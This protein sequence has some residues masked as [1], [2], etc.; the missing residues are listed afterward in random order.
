[1]EQTLQHHGILGQKW[2]VRRYQNPDGS[3]TPAG[4]R[5]LEKLDQKWARKQGTKIKKQVERSVRSDMRPVDRYLNKK[6]A[7]KG[8]RYM[9]ERNQHLANLMNSKIG[10][11]PA[12]SGRVLRFVAKRGDLGVHVALADANYNMKNLK[13]GVYANGKVAYKK[14]NVEVR[15][16]ENSGYYL[17]HVEGGLSLQHHGIKG[18]RWGVRR[19][20][21]ED[22]S[23]TVAGAR[24]YNYKDSEAF[25]KAGFKDR[26]G[27]RAE[28]AVNRLKYGKKAANVAAYAKYEQ[29]DDQVNTN[30]ALAKRDQQIHNLKVAGAVAGAAVAGVVI[31]K[32]VKN[33]LNAKDAAKS[34]NGVTED[35]VKNLIEE[36][37]KKNEKKE[38]SE[39]KNEKKASESK[40]SEPEKKKQTLMEAAKEV[41]KKDESSDSQSWKDAGKA[42]FSKSSEKKVSEVVAEADARAKGQSIVSKY[43][44]QRR[45]EKE[46]D[47]AVSTQAA[48]ASYQSKVNLNNKAVQEYGKQAQAWND[49]MNAAKRAKKIETAAKD[50][51]RESDVVKK[52]IAAADRWNATRKK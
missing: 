25:K 47:R 39:P 51:V 41:F 43:L 5:H 18:Q 19:Y 48:R 35:T 8:L 7:T 34:S 21:N 24:R 16:M 3:Y 37:S 49:S 13:S 6:Y 28:Y 32:L 23:L 33:K 4:I 40:S 29:K 11:I 50:S 42:V 14:D 9:A 52:A 31:A 30:A 44:E 26:M 2:G 12:P 10:D 1:M 27:M 36:Y 46:T 45:Q 17:A 15:H 22:G 20:Q 38:T